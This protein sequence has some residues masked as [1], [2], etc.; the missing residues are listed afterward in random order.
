MNK[1]QTNKHENE[2]IIKKIYGFNNRINEIVKMCIKLELIHFS[3]KLKNI[4]NY[5]KLEN[6]IY[7]ELGNK[8]FS[9]GITGESPFFKDDKENES[10]VYKAIKIQIQEYI[11]K[12][13]EI[14]Q[15]IDDY[16]KEAYE[17][18]KKERLFKSSPISSVISLDILEKIINIKLNEYEKNNDKLYDYKIEKN[19][20]E[21]IKNIYVYA[22]KESV[23]KKEFYKNIIPKIMQEFECLGL[24]VEKEH[25]IEE[26]IV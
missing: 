23:D 2:N 10:Y 21:I 18:Y 20:D 12:S 8:L 7:L 15:M 26:K 25:L 1:E 17:S 5:H 22:R 4:E 13:E 14:I 11:R 19:I 24:K 6:H 9:A 16:T 3:N